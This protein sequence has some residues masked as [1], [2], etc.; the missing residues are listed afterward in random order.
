MMK[1]LKKLN[2]RYVKTLL[3]LLVL[4]YLGKVVFEAARTPRFLFK[5][6]VWVHRVNSIQKLNEVKSHYSGIE[7]DIV[8]EK[9]K[10]Y[11]DV[12]HPPAPS[13]H[14]S[15]L[16]YFKA[17]T[18]HPD[19][20]YWLDFKNLRAENKESAL[21][22]LDSIAHLL[23]LNKKNIIV[24]STRPQFLK[25]FQ[26]SGFLTSYY[27]PYNLHELNAKD[28]KKKM[29]GVVKNLKS[30][31]TDYVSANYKHY[32]IMNDYFPKKKKLTWLTGAP[33]FENKWKNRWFIY[34][35]LWDENIEV[36]LFRVKSERGDR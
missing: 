17:Q 31:E 1:N 7:L 22:H 30:S 29:A 8:F 5:D 12:N 21:Q 18:T 20:K 14:L 28:L 19:L 13:I 16:D 2:N 36:V 23:Q 6:K 10:H 25:K 9:K 15:L 24:E 26:E 35:M 34:K 32:D 27:L 11:F 4:G 3:L 33:V